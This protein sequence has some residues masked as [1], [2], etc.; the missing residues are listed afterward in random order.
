MPRLSWRMWSFL[1]TSVK[2]KKPWCIG[3]RLWNSTR[4]IRHP[5]IDL[6]NY[7][8]HNGPIEKAFE[9]YSKAISLKPTEALYYENFAA[10]VYLFRRDAE[11]FQDHRAAG[12]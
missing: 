3:K 8:G 4:K 2:R 12:F 1:T 6:A 5:E 10:T 7:Y 9:Y 11:L